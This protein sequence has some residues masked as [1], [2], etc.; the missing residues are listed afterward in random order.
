[1]SKKILS[2]IGVVLLIAIICFGFVFAYLYFSDD[3]ST[4]Y[5]SLDSK[6]I[7]TWDAISCVDPNGNEVQPPTG[8]RFVFEE[9]NNL[10]YYTDFSVL[11]DSYKYSWITES[12]LEINSIVTNTTRS[13][14]L[15]F[16]NNHMI[17]ND[18]T[19]NSIWTLQKSK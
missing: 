5:S 13:V 4:D 19:Y 2:T 9:G 8:N 3:K 7:G 15:S 6:V 10:K 17:V 14:Y 1:M 18:P 16:N 11:T 12:E